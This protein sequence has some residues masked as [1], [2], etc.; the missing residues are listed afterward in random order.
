MF[1]YMKAY[2]LVFVGGGLGSLLRY[3]AGRLLPATING[4]PF[5]SAIL[6]VNVVASALLSAVVGWTLARSASDDVRLL[7]GVGFCGGLSTFSSFSNDTLAL[8]QNGRTG[9]A[10][11]NI[12]LNVV[13]CLLASTGGLLIGQKL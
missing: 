12:A 9:V 4:V 11:L 1:V 8:L 5:P 3:V 7:I 2:L 13:L 10:F 6:L